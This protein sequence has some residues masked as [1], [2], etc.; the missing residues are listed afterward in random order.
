MARHSAQSILERRRRRKKESRAESRAAR[1]SESR[2]EFECE[3]KRAALRNSVSQTIISRLVNGLAYNSGRGKETSGPE[4]FACTHVRVRAIS[5]LLDLAA[6]F[7]FK[8]CER[9]RPACVCAI[10]QCLKWLRKACVNA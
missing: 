2:A 1:E 8:T 6:L 5:P 7:F 9:A 10:E 3:S 4:S